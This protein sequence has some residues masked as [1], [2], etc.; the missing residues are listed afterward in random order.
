MMSQR[1]KSKMDKRVVFAALETLEKRQLLTS[2][3]GGSQFEFLQYDGT[4]VSVTVE[5]PSTAVLELIGATEN[6]NGSGGQF[7]TLNNIPG[8]FTRG[9]GTNPDRF[10][11]LGGADGVEPIDTITGADDSL[12]TV[13]AT[14]IGGPFLTAPRAAIHYDAMSS[15]SAGKTYAISLQDAGDANQVWLTSVNYTSSGQGTVVADIAGQIVAATPGAADTTDIQQIV[16][17]DFMP[18]ADNLLYFIAI[19]NVP[20][21]PA[22][23][24]DPTDTDVP[25]LYYFDLNAPD[26]SLAI[27]SRGAPITSDPGSFSADVVPDVFAMTMDDDGNMVLFVTGREAAGS[28]ENATVAERTGLVVVDVP[29]SSDPTPLP[30]QFTLNDV[31][32][33]L[34]NG[35]AVEDL[36]GI[37]AVPG[38]AG[39]VYGISGDAGS[40]VLLHVNVNT[41]VAT[42]FGGLPDPDD[43]R[44]TQRGSDL[45]DLVWNPRLLSQF[46][47]IDDN[48]NND[49]RRGALIAQDQTTDELVFVDTSQRFATTSLYHMRLTNGTPDTRVSIAVRSET[50]PFPLL[51]F[52]GSIGQ[53]RHVDAQG[54]PTLLSTPN[55]G[56]GQVLVGLRTIDV[57]DSTTEEEDIPVRRIKKTPSQTFGNFSKNAKYVYAGLSA[58]GDVGNFLVGGTV[59]GRVTWEG[60]I[61]GALYAGEFLTGDPFGRNETASFSD[62][63]GNIYVSGDARNIIARSSIGSTEITGATGPSYVT[64]ADV[65][66]GGKLGQLLAL[67][68]MYGNINVLGTAPGLNK[69]ISEVEERRTPPVEGQTYFEGYGGVG[70]SL[71]D[72]ADFHN[73]SADVQQFVGTHLS[74]AYRNDEVAVINGSLDNSSDVN[75]AVDNYAISL[76][77]GQTIH[78]RLDAQ[79]A[80]SVGLFDSDGRLVATDQSD[81]GSGVVAG[82]EFTYKVDRPGVYRVAVAYWDDIDYSG[83]PRSQVSGKASYTLRLTNV[84]DISLGAAVTGGSFNS[85]SRSATGIRVAN[86]DL[87]AV[88]SKTAALIDTTSGWNIEKGNV[89]AL[90]AATEFGTVT[91]TTELGNGLNLSVARGSVGLLRTGETMEFNDFSEQSSDRTQTIGGDFQWIDCGGRFVGNISADRGVGNFHAASVSGG[92]YWTIN[93]DGLGNDGYWG[94]CDVTGDLGDV[95]T[96]GP[97]IY[98][99]PGGNFGYMRIGGEV[100]APF[101]FGRGQRQLTEYGPGEVVRLTDDSGI[102]VKLTPTPQVIIGSAND[103]NEIAAPGRLSVLTYPVSDTAK[104]GVIIVR[105]NLDSSPLNEANHGLMVQSGGGTIGGGSIEIGEINTFESGRP[106]VVTGTPSLDGS[107]ELSIKPGTRSGDEGFVTPTINSPV[108][109]QFKGDSPINIWEIEARDRGGAAFSTIDSISNSTSG[110]I[111]NVIASAIGDL[112]AEH[113]GIPQSHWGENKQHT[114]LTLMKNEKIDLVTLFG[115]GSTPMPTADTGITLSAGGGNLAGY[116][117]SAR[118]R[119]EIG[120]IFVSG[121]IGSVV[122]NSNN[123]NNKAVYEGIVGPVIA[124]S[125]AIPFTG[126]I[127]SVNIGEGLG[128]TGTGAIPFGSLFAASTIS[129][130]TNQGLGSDIRGDIIVGYAPLAP[131]V[132]SQSI[133]SIRLSDGAIIDADIA[134]T[135]DVNQFY[136]LQAR[137]FLA[138]TET[139]DNINDPRFEIGEIVLKGRGG[140]IGTT[141]RAADIDTINVKG[142]FGILNSQIE[143][144]GDNKIATVVTDGYG[145]RDTAIGSGAT[146]DN[147]IVN[148]TGKDIDANWYTPSVLN[149]RGKEGI[150]PYS[151]QLYNELNDLHRYLGTSSK[152]GKIKGVTKS[153]IIE[154]S[155]INATRNLGKLE[156]YQIVGRQRTTRIQFGNQIDKVNV[157]HAVDN[158]ILSTGKLKGFTTGNDVS[159]SRIGVAGMADNI[160]VGGTFRGT[161]TLTVTGPQGVLNNLTTGNGLFGVVNV[162]NN[163]GTIHVGNDFGSRQVKGLANMASLIVDGSVLGS[164]RVDIRGKLTQIAVGKDVNDGAVIKAKSNDE[165]LVKGDLLGDIIIG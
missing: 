18:G 98:T 4:R 83:N 30:V 74:K 140:I 152:K 60:N 160:T 105:V 107:T 86:G 15:N 116:L 44:D 50:T 22:G 77:A 34:L 153:G 62:V 109:L 122:A 11:G 84:A 1:G 101:T 133:K 61:A 141:I 51:P 5:G 12:T 71:G 91:S 53:I 19:V 132:D 26:A 143:S 23:G 24:G 16:A 59:L 102:E 80:L 32:P 103:P 21:P 137:L 73:D 58:D 120:N 138:D 128:P 104:N 78:L 17:A 159:F 142:G 108:D 39:F 57:V 112:S 117:V 72:V 90:V 148:G 45:T 56:T 9:G 10:G 155:Q 119:Q 92:G 49:N 29:D 157:R 65:L 42:N 33:V 126:R 100:W 41:G 158:M 99:G 35:E 94:L 93:A 151:G 81:I 124:G 131:A 36:R 129:Q 69:S 43:T 55:E 28:G 68:A 146:V 145:I 97:N 20:R 27:G 66:V 3:P 52:T 110:E 121:I 165:Q 70:P 95:S 76:M 88:V 115:P 6:N 106:I 37:E 63:A 96:G 162:T 79:G 136:E 125:T 87:G 82:K 127:Q 111:V 149:S 135:S 14:A 7:A 47:Q 89:R 164:A 130:I 139:L 161:S 134:V 46:N 163:I 154:D 13:D 123:K 113:I 48:P 118:S 114:G 156:A 40:A 147:V 8:I 25:F 64:G 31:Q 2:V 144:F 54:G 67:D 85:F 38:D 150:D 75:D